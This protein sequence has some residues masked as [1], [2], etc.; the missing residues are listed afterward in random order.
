M[1]L[2]DLFGGSSHNVTTTST[3]TPFQADQLRT[4]YGAAEANFN[5]GTPD[6]SGSTATSQDA[7]N[8]YLQLA[9]Q[10]NPAGVE[11]AQQTLFNAGNPSANPAFQQYL[12]FLNDEMTRSFER[13]LPRIANEGVMT[14]TLA[15]SDQ[16][17]IKQLAQEN[18]LRQI[19]GQTA[20]AI[21]Q[22]YGTGLNAVASG[23][24]ANPIVNAARTLPADLTTNAANIQRGNELLPFSLNQDLLQQYANIITPNVGG[25][26]TQTGPAQRTGGLVGALGGL[27]GG[28]GLAQLLPESMASYSPW[29]IGAGG[30]AG[31]LS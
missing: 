5:A 18:L 17:K 11:G 7:V 13:T 15:G 12:Q 10:M 31:L 1:G 6:I 25:T 16:T 24:Q 19:G 30:L 4:L 29:L 8:R 21:N 22:A 28:A 20:G 27:A 9:N 2:G 3:F 26:T 23:I 14:G